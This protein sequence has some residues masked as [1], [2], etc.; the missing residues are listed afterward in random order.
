MIAA[1][2]SKVMASHLARQAYLY[3]RQSTLRQ[4]VENQESTQRQYALRQ[5]AVAL[6][7]APDDIVVIDKDL[8]QS[9]A[10]A[11]D[12]EGFQEL[13]SAVSLGRAGIVLGLEVSR[14]AR[15]STDW[16]RLLEIC[17]LTET[18]ILDEDGIY[19]PAHFNDRLLLGLKGTMSEAELHVLRS[20]LRGGILNA[21]RRGALRWALPIGFVRDET[22]RT[23]LDPDQQ[24]Q[25]AVRLLFETFWRLGTACSTV[26]HFNQQGLLFPKRLCNGPRR[27]E[28][29]WD[30]LG[31][32]RTMTIL[33]NPC[34]A[35]A[36]VYGR[37]RSRKLPDGRTEYRK[38]ARDAWLVFLRDA[39]PGYISW[40]E[41][42]RIQQQLRRSAQAYGIDRRGPPREGPALLQGLAVCG[43]CGIRMSVRYHYRRNTTVPDYTCFIHTIEHREPPC[44]IIPG[45]AIDEAIGK[46]LVERMTPMAL[47]VTLAVQAEIQ[48]RLDDADKLRQQQVER[49]DYEAELARR[50]YMK[51]DP[52]NRLVADALE[53][54]WNE[55]LR[56]TEKARQDCEKQRERDRAILDESQRQ[57]I[58]ALAADFAAI[59]NDPATPHRERKR[60]A[61]LLIED[62]T[63]I[64]GEQIIAHV[65][66][67]GGATTTL[68]LPRPLN[69][70]KNRQTPKPVIERLDASQHLLEDHTDA[71][72][73][74]ILN[75]QGAATGAGGRFDRHAIDW[76]RRR[77]RIKSLRERLRDKGMMSIAEMAHH[78]GLRE[79]EVRDLRACGRL[80]GRTV[81]DKGE[82][83][84]EPPAEDIVSSI[85]RTKAAAEPSR[86]AP[87]TANASTKRGAV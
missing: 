87:R 46:H 70:W 16:H 43:I 5:R 20:R 19:D 10:S 6:G 7:W 1:E 58:R 44:Q 33:H 66:F 26:K 35:G 13:V 37:L 29:L 32:Q 12:R 31:M 79:W 60:M 57:R 83:M 34:Y 80:Q 25:Q 14:L 50:R 78:L 36:Y 82:W 81:N 85:R 17:A 72:A 22:S 28:V 23:V 63:L 68:T 30:R 54:G 71:Q 18:L 47:E 69:A 8:G 40:D 9:G 38:V 41:H 24:V 39:H 61:A 73:A 77:W 2:P 84:L 59:C 55:K 64:K 52:D 86:N 27:G 76:I 74:A 62:V 75:E 48:Q 53:A 4:V 45:A 15:N 42:E 65:R 49:A 3:V 56:A 51:V 67:R 11:V 21:A